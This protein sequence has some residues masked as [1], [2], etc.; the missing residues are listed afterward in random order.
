M[1]AAYLVHFVT[2]CLLAK[3]LTQ[4]AK[5][6]WVGRVQKWREANAQEALFARGTRDTDT[7]EAFSHGP[8]AGCVA[9]VMLLH[10]NAGKT[11]EFIFLAHSQRARL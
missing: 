1:A 10:C 5:R 7:T 2:L 11:S 4:G 8:C 6:F 9:R 3:R